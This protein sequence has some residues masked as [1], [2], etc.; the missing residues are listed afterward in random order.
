MNSL[1][2]TNKNDGI[3]TT[4]SLINIYEDTTQKLSPDGE[5]MPSL[6]EIKPSDD[7]FSDL[8]DII[9]EEEAST[10]VPPQTDEPST[11]SNAGVWIALGVAGGI[12]VVAAAVVFVLFKLGI[13]NFKGKRK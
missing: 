10:F 9:G 2:E 11:K 6:S 8:G 5:K 7:K 1:H 3:F 4:V 12:L 13:I